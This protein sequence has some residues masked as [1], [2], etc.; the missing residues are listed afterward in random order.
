MS[1]KAL[2]CALCR[3][4]LV[5]RSLSPRALE[6]AGCSS[7]VPMRRGMGS[8]LFA[9]VLT[10]SRSIRDGERRLRRESNAAVRRLESWL[11]PGPDQG[12]GIVIMGQKGVF[13]QKR[14]KFFY[15]TKQSNSRPGLRC[16]T[17][18]L[19]AAYMR[20][21]RLSRSNQVDRD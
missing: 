14:Q 12:A 16:N 20:E 17:S 9:A 5:I 1:K 15:L 2:S 4:R 6:I 13:Q 10:Y 7:S 18:R 8:L 19:T 3:F 11:D 21:S